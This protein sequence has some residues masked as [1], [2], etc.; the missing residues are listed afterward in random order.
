MRRLYDGYILGRNGGLPLQKNR[1]YPN[2]CRIEKR[3][4]AYA[5]CVV[6]MKGFCFI[7]VFYIFSAVVVAM[8][9]SRAGILV[10][11][12]SSASWAGIPSQK[13]GLPK[14]DASG[15]AQ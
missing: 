9:M 5:G 6:D 4:P 2:N 12:T 13:A 3:N 15:R 8:H 11:S 14:R 7:Y 1:I 10:A